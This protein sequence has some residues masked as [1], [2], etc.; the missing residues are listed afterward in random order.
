MALRREPA[1]MIG[2]PGQRHLPGA[3]MVGGANCIETERT[4]RARI[5]DQQRSRP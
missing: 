5:P 1:R 3:K 4:A 2:R